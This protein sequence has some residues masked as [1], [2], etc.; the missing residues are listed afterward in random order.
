MIKKTPGLLAALCIVFGTAFG[1]ALGI[2][3]CTAAYGSTKYD[4][5]AAQPKALFQQS[6]LLDRGISVTSSGSY[7][8]YY[9]T[10]LFL[11]GI[12]L[13]ETAVQAFLSAA[14]DTV[15]RKMVHHLMQMALFSAHNHLSAGMRTWLIYKVLPLA[16]EGW[17]LAFNIL[18]KAY[19]LG[20]LTWERAQTTIGRKRLGRMPV[21]PGGLLDRSVFID[22]LIATREED[23]N[24]YHLVITP[25]QK[26]DTEAL[27]TPWEKTLGQLVNTA[28]D[29]GV[30]TIRIKTRRYG[31][32]NMDW[33]MA[34]CRMPIADAVLPAHGWATSKL[35]PAPDRSQ[36]YLATWLE[37]SWTHTVPA[38]GLFTVLDPAGLQCINDRLISPNAPCLPLGKL[39]TEDTPDNGRVFS[40]THSAATTET[41]RSYLHI[42][43]NRSLV[44]GSPGSIIVSSNPL[45]P[46]QNH[47]STS[48]QYRMSREAAII[49]EYIIQDYLRKLADYTLGTGIEAA[50]RLKHGYLTYRQVETMNSRLPDSVQKVK[51]YNGEHFI[52]KEAHL[53]RNNNN[54]LITRKPVIGMRYG[55]LSGELAVVQKLDG[56]HTAKLHDYW[57][58]NAGTEQAKLVALFEDAGKD[59]STS[60]PG[61]RRELKGLVRGATEAVKGLHDAGY[62]HFDVK[63]ENFVIDN[64]GQVRLIDLEMAAPINRHGQA[65]STIFDPMWAAPEM[66]IRTLTSTKADIWTLGAT[67]LSLYSNSS[68]PGAN[69]IPKDVTLAT[70]S[71][72]LNAHQGLIQLSEKIKGENKLDLPADFKDFLQHSLTTDPENRLSAGELLRH[73]YLR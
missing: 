72:Y 8:R 39:V 26:V 15:Y 23:K 35:Y 12:M 32:V 64:G 58:E 73:P 34:A 27:A 28:L 52:R 33:H 56:E 48:G 63:P 2:G 50:Y 60:R 7:L 20:S 49:A 16:F 9:G 71:G 65:V 47:R 31:E 68:L 1:T 10:T 42:I 22:Y 40:F 45:L 70:F 54:E 44:P 57:I 55:F 25:L 59:L 13:P 29:K 4:S 24:S 21:Y 53:I 19:N 18:P 37:R 30:D 6:E 17:N 14:G 38:G 46:R 41:D 11:P 36:N 69:R 61:S 43:N 62:A 3:C 5:N 67:A 51:N 66:D